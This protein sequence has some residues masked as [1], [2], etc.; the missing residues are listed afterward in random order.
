MFIKFWPKKKIRTP[1]I[2][3]KIIFISLQYVITR[4]TYIICN[5]CIKQQNKS[6]ITFKR[7]KFILTTFLKCTLKNA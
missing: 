7:Y 3:I 5:V 2:N 6:L 1:I 4:I